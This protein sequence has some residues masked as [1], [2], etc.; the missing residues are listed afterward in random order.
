[1]KARPRGLD[2]L[3]EVKVVL[4]VLIVGAPSSH[5]QSSR[6]GR[7]APAPSGRGEVAQRLTGR[8]ITLLV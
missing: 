1:V 6:S 8:V 7:Q 2:S 3:D 4:Y 5:R